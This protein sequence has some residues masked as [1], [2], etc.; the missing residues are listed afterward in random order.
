MMAANYPHIGDLE[1][2][3]G[4]HYSRFSTS[5]PTAPLAAQSLARRKSRYGGSNRRSRA[6]VPLGHRLLHLDR[7]AHRID[8]ATKL[9]QQAVAGGLDDAAAVLG[10][11]RVEEL[12]AQRLEAFVRAFF[13][14]PHQP[15]IPRD[16]GGEDRSEAASLAHSGNPA[17]RIAARDS[18]IND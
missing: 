12:M 11:L 8:D 7:A 18:S 1:N 4:R 5:E 13:V 16:I 17:S 14:G 3:L 9:H 10:D 15:R 2:R 6:S